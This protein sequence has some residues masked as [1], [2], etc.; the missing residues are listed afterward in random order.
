MQTPASCPPNAVCIE[1][2]PWPCD[3]YVQ[4]TVAFNAGTTSVASYLFELTFDH[5]WWRCWISRPGA[6]DDV[7]TNQLAFPTGKVRD[8]PRTTPQPQHPQQ[9]SSLSPT[10]RFKSWGIREIH[11][12]WPSGSQGCQEGKELLATPPFNRSRRQLSAARSK[13]NRHWEHGNTMQGTLSAARVFRMVIAV[14]MLSV[15]S[16]SLGPPMPRISGMPITIEPRSGTTVEF[17][18]QEAWRRTAFSCS[19][20]AI[21]FSFVS[22]SAPDGRPGVGDFIFTGT[23]NTGDGGFVCAVAGDGHRHRE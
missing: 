12:H 14:M 20:P 8:L 17:T 10:L 2:P 13:C 19:N 21:P 3:E 6:F 11:L 7:I 23:F 16:G 9:D 18:L 1:L 15:F 22:C 5:M 4:V